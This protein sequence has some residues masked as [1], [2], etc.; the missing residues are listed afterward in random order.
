[1]MADLIKKIVL[2]HRVPATLIVCMACMEKRLG[3]RESACAIVP[4]SWSYQRRGMACVKLKA[5]VCQRMVAWVSC[6]A[7]HINLPIE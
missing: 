6:P 1:M 2:R 3:A 4:E 7:L 5:H